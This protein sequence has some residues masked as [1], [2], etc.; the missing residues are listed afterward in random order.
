HDIFQHA[1][2]FPAAE[3]VD[4]PLSDEALQFHKSGRPFL[5]NQLPFWMATAIG[6]LIILLIPILGVLY[7]MMRFLPNL[8][9]WMM[10]S[11]I[12]RLYGELRFLE[13][14]IE[15][16]H[17]VGDKENNMREIAARLDRLEGQATR[18]K[19]PLSYASMLYILQNHIDLVRQ[20]LHKE[21]TQKP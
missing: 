12:S 3:T 11:K 7:P 9:D 6:K 17:G 20:R 14:E 8:F 4:F 18:L 10:R 1:N 13:E 21:P 15:A 19:M 16:A 5:H 2:E